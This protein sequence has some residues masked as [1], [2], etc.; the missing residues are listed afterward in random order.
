MNLEVNEGMCSLY[1]SGSKLRNVSPI[2]TTKQAIWFSWG[3]YDMTNVTLSYIR[4]KMVVISHNLVY[5]DDLNTRKYLEFFRRFTLIQVNISHFF[6]SGVVI[7]IMAW[8]SFVIVIVVGSS[9]IL[10][11]YTHF[12]EKN[13]VYLPKCKMKKDLSFA[14]FIR[15]QKG[16]KENSCSDYGVSTHSFQFKRT[17]A[18]IVL[19]LK[20]YTHGKNDKSYIQKNVACNKPAICQLTTGRANNETLNQLIGIVDAFF[21]GNWS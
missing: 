19:I 1:D 6:K 17:L 12:H 3:I 4:I 11:L 21:K 15:P 18:F 16:M 8:I 20:I 2:F 13:C 10:Q 7:N 9:L 14:V 5:Y